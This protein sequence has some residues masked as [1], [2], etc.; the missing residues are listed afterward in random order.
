[1]VYIVYIAPMLLSSNLEC[2]CIDYESYAI[3]KQTQSATR[4]FVCNVTREVL[5]F[6]PDLYRLLFLITSIVEPG[7][8]LGILLIFNGMRRTCTDTG[9]TV[10][11]VLTPDRFIFG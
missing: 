6:I 3:K 4:A 5:D 7:F 10:S 9:H 1:M 2:F 11:T 8:S